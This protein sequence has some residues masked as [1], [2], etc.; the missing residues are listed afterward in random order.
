[1]AVGPLPARVLGRGHSFFLLDSDSGPKGCRK[2]SKDS[3]SGTFGAVL[4]LAFNKIH[5]LFAFLFGRN[6]L[7]V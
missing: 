3:G 7:F 6:S 5:Y 4:S 2:Y 1:M